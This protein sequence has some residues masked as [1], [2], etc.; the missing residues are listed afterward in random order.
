LDGPFWLWKNRG[1]DTLFENLFE[2]VRVFKRGRNSHY[3]SFLTFY[4]FS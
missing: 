2:K 1:K 4:C 3:L